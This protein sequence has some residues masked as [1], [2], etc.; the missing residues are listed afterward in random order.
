MRRTDLTDSSFC[1]GLGASLPEDLSG[2][3][4]QSDIDYRTAPISNRGK[5]LIK[6]CLQLVPVLDAVANR[7]S[8]GLSDLG[9]VG[10][11]T[12]TH[13][14]LV[15]SLSGAFW[16]HGY[17]RESWRLPTAV[18]VD[19][20]EV[21]CRVRSCHPVRAAGYAKE[22]TAVTQESDDLGVRL[23]KFDAYGCVGPSAESRSMVLEVAPG[24]IHLQDAGDLHGR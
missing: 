10:A 15:V 11:G 14:I 9:Q 8:G 13:P 23:G 17:C 18:V 22:E 6:C 7:A 4:L 5:C 1:K 19:D 16:M 12:N 3:P 2:R 24:A 21:R 20:R